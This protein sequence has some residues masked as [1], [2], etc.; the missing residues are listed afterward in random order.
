MTKNVV[1]PSNLKFE[2]TLSVNDI[3]LYIST[4][5]NQTYYEQWKNHE[6]DDVR[7]EL[8]SA[9]Y[10]PEH[11]ITDD[12]VEIRTIVLFKHPEYLS[13]L[14]EKNDFNSA[15]MSMHDYLCEQTQ[16]DSDII[17]D[18]IK[19]LSQFKECDNTK[20]A[21]EIKLKAMEASNDDYSKMTPQQLYDA[22][23]PYWAKPL[24]LYRIFDILDVAELLNEKGYNNDKLYPLLS[25]QLTDEEFDQKLN[26]MVL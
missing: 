20:A 7:Y 5:T 15:H 8:A 4:G 24:S 16:I 21:F 17:K 3:I 11:F 25:P 9:G 18:H 22:K 6:S 2:N 23:L 12:C 13:I 14:K 1:E 10:F 19:F 26:N